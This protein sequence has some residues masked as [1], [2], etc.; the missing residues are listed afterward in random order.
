VK[1]HLKAPQPGD[2][3]DKVFASVPINRVAR[4]VTLQPEDLPEPPA[5]PTAD[6]VQ[7]YA[8]YYPNNWRECPALLS[9]TKIQQIEMRRTRTNFLKLRFGKLRV[10]GIAARRKNDDAHP[11]RWVVQCDC[12]S[13][14]YRKTNTIRKALERGLTRCEDRCSRCD[15]NQRRSVGLE[16]EASFAPI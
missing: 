7:S 13:Y 1:L 11:R 9:L 8:D 16:A 5:A 10:I 12:G 6:P 15:D 4:R 3:L 14:E 2:I